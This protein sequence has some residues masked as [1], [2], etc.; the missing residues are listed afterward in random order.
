[1]CKFTL[2]PG[3]SFMAGIT[4]F[5]SVAIALFIMAALSGATFA[6]DPATQ[7]VT[8]NQAK[9]SD[10]PEHVKRLADIKYGDGP[11]KSNLLDVYIS[12]DPPADK[13]LPLVV[14]VHGGGW[15]SG[16]KEGC[17]AV[18]LVPRGYIVAS[19]NYRLSQQAVYPAQIQD[20]KGAIRFLRAHA[21]DYH[22]DPDKIGVWGASAG[23][24]LVAL[25][26]TSSDSKDVEGTVGGN[27]DQSSRVQAVCDWFGPTDLTQFA[28]EAV[29]AG[30]I[31]ST[32]GP[33]LI[34][35]LFGGSLQQKRDLVKQANPISFIDKSTAKDIPPFLIMHGEKDKMVPVAQS[36]LLDDALKAAGVSSDFQT[37]PDAGHG[38]GFNTP[39]IART[40]SDFF[41]A[42]LKTTKKP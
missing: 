17:P 1:M 22:I 2:K 11:E 37:I 25:L 28:D 6:A 35:S 15:S 14:W 20:C 31:K 30:I 38:N 24:H 29:A 3:H 36:Q 7:P 32:P 26:G 39:K 21:K 33:T 10:L 12:D 4:L 34:M 23:G 5:K 18:P 42:N 16:S 41:D 8:K 40:V 13:P 9:K 27:A 19:I